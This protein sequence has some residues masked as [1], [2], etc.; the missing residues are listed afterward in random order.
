MVGSFIYVFLECCGWYRAFISYAEV[1]AT[2]V[3]SSIVQATANQLEDVDTMVSGWQR[4]FTVTE[5]FA[6]VSGLIAGVAGC[7]VV[8]FQI[9][10]DFSTDAPV[11]E[12]VLDI[13]QV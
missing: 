7:V 13:C 12:K 3:D 5:E 11:A 10:R 2:E 9:S 6:Q 1:D 8:G 4:M